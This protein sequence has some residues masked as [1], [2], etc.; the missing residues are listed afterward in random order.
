M[1][2]R[3]VKPITPQEAEEARKN[4]VPSFVIEAV[5]KLLKKKWNGKEAIIT[6][7]EI[8]SE[9]K[10]S[11]VLGLENGVRFRGAVFSN[12]WLDFEDLYRESGWKIEYDKPSY[13]E[14]YK[15]YF[16]FTKK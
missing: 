5:N 1:D 14:S 13:C 7:E 8:I 2:V 15:A 6:Q 4:A 12:H 3:E 11:N 9:I 10:P 16:K